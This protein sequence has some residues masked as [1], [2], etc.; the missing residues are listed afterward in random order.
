LV[1]DREG[2]EARLRRLEDCV[3]ELRR[4][5]PATLETYTRDRGLRDRCERNLQVAI[6]C[7]LDAGNHIIAEEI[8]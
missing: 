4:I 6:Q 7:A 8:L 5:R 1:V 3:S 2:I